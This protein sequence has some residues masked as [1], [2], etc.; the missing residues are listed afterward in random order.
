MPAREE[1]VTCGKQRTRNLKVER[2][3]SRENSNL[4]ASAIIIRNRD[5]REESSPISRDAEAVHN[6]HPTSH[7]GPL[8]SEGVSGVAQFLLR[9]GA[10]KGD[11]VG[12][13]RAEEHVGQQPH[14]DGLVEEHVEAAG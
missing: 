13:G 10:V 3:C 9:D 1:S 14:L 2:S 8:G 12:L 7:E 11:E 6:I 5:V 4:S